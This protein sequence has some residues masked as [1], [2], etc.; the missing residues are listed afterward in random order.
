M[1]N[2][3]KG[4][5]QQ[6]FTGI[7]FRWLE[8]ERIQLVAPT[9]AAH[10][11]PPLNPE[12]ST[13]LAAFDGEYLIGF[14]VMECVPHVEPL[15]V[16]AAYRGRGIPLA[17]VTQMVDFLYSVNAPIAYMVANSP[18]SEELARAY[19]MTKIEK[20]VYFKRGS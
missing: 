10:G 3:E 18:Y 11:W 19:G 14:M 12:L 17:L 20:P 13:V 9:I 1:S 7:T 6:T 16:S 5:I 2:S 15:W 4:L 8:R